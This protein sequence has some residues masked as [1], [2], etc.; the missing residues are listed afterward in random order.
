MPTLNEGL[1]QAVRRAVSLPSKIALTYDAMKFADGAGAQLQ[2]IY[3]TYS[4]ARLINASYVHTPLGR[5]DYQ[6]LLALESGAHDPD[7]HRELNAVFHIKSDSIA[8]AEFHVVALNAI[9]MN[10]IGAL[11]DGFDA[12]VTGGR[13]ILVKLVEPYGI[14]DRFPDCYDVCR[15]ISPF[16]AAPREHRPVRVAIHVRRGELL[17]VDSHRMLSNAYYVKVAQSLVD[18]FNRLAIDYRLELHTEV[19]TKEFVVQP[20]DRGIGHL[21][22]PATV[23]PDMYGL[24][25]FDI[26]PNLV[27]RI[28]EAP[29]DCFRQLATADVLVMS[30]SS[31]SYVAAILNRT[32][33]ILH[34]PFWHA[35][36]SRWLTVDP[37]GRFNRSTF[38]KYLESS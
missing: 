21:V 17:V 6:G 20:N 38:V 2:R 32:G 11:A 31:F 10:T 26:L 22:A 34:H 9:S 25:E 29:L 1:V 8:G 18:I 14:A 24:H 27:Y 12:G 33:V 7:Y 4:I 30:R 35:A 36:P 23:R 3:G 19:A 13:P 28:N 16:S 5:V 37:R 15:G